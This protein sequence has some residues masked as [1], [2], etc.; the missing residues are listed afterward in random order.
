MF[1]PVKMSKINILLLNKYVTD[2]TRMLGRHGVLHLVDAVKQSDSGMLK[3]VEERNESALRGLISRCER[4]MEGLGISCEGASIQDD[5][6]R[7][8]M[9]QDEISHL[10][11]R[12][13]SRYAEQQEAITGLL[14][15]TGVIRKESQEMEMFPLQDV[16]LEVLRNLSHFHL[17]VGR[18][19]LTVIPRVKS[20][21]SERAIVVH[22]GADASGDVLVLSS[23]KSRWAVKDVLSRFGFEEATVPED[24][25]GSVHD[26]VAEKKDELGELSRKLSECRM[27]VLKLGEEYGEVLVAMH[28]QLLCLEAV[29]KV[30]GN[31]G[32]IS[33][34]Y[35]ISGWVPDEKVAELKRAVDETTGGT[36]IVE[37]I[38]ASEDALVK[39]GV[40][41]VPVKFRPHPLLRPFQMLITNF[42]L[43]G[44]NEIDPSLFVA[45]TFVVLFGFMFGDVGQGA[46]L[47]LA[48]AWM[49]WTKRS[50]GDTVRDAGVLLML[51]GGSAMVF[52]VLYG[53][54]FGYEHLFPALWVNPIRPDDISHLLLT[55]VG[56]GIVFSSMAILINIINHFMAKR[57]F[58]GVFDRFGVLG[59]LFYWT[60]L[61][62][63]V[64]MINTGRCPVIA[65]VMIATPLV[66][67]LL[68]GLL[69]HFFG[70]R[71]EE[72]PESML[73]VVI[74]SCIELMETF[75]G[76]ISGTVSFVRV[77]AFAISHAALCMAIFYVVKSLH[78]V[79]G[80]GV[81]S[82]LV[83][84]L[85]NLVI[86]G[87][88]GMVAMI[89]GI[90]LE[91][92][93]LF[94]K[95]F[96]GSGIAYKPFVFDVKKED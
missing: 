63:G 33:K 36:G 84:A 74:E 26:A 32:R 71:H 92:Y 3:G 49:K 93:E 54:V 59:L 51:C 39:A 12:I 11:T 64:Y 42:G 52:G 27:N 50:L 21:L 55:A 18:L 95:Y 68:K 19:P 7:Q 62:T 94:G 61:G 23:S 10:L 88:E 37:A 48:G 34:L 25:T 22:T 80:Q 47:A 1:K 87:F 96:S 53:S 9:G 76:Y 43:P 78:G 82:F 38:P 58:D 40:E 17:M 46:V 41:N 57:F 56:V 5:I 73:N 31:F 85:G 75:T 69:K 4:L 2:V 13:Y 29:Q 90:R 83:I 30:Q 66:L 16:S 86:I 65:I 79:S 70:S 72:E 45:I 81:W 28:T 44:Y 67:L 14:K 8:E 91:Y 77:G 20:E 60:A 89:Q 35:C 15:N 24:A 6:T